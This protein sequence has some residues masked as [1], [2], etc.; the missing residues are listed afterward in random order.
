MLIPKG[1]HTIIFESEELFILIFSIFTVLEN[2][3]ILFLSFEHTIFINACT[4][5]FKS[6][7]TN[8][9]FFVYGIYRLVVA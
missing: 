9:G 7:S 5:F 1:K 2:L 6:L 3:L 8:A 4:D